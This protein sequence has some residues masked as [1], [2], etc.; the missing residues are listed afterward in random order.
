[1][2]STQ[3][4]RV[5]WCARGAHPTAS[6]A[7]VALTLVA[8]L[9]GFGT[10]PVVDRDEARFAEASR[11]MVVAGWPGG[12]LVP[13]LQGRPRLNKP[14]LVYWLQAASVTALGM[15]RNGPWPTNIW[16]YRLPSLAGM[17]V[18]VWATWR[19]GRTM[20]APP[21]AWLGAAL[22]ACAPLLLWEARQARADAVLLAATVVA[23]WGLWRI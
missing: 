2:V 14:P 15:P 7:L 1:M 12:Y 21:A 22:L 5:T 10:L 16:V 6:A 11:E 23:Q 9:P 13:T 17:I 19:M 8:Y 3:S 20:F 18:A 4:S